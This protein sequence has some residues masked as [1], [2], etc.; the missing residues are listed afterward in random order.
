HSLFPLRYSA[1]A[2]V[3]LLSYAHGTGDVPLLGQTIGDNLRAT[4]DRHGD[5][6]ALVVCSQK[7]RLSYRQLWD[8]TTRVARGLL[9]LGVKPGERVGIWA[10]NRYE[11]VV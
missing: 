5:R 7:A 6:E 3:S 11:W 9:A 4:A 2:G 10:S 8:A 1:M